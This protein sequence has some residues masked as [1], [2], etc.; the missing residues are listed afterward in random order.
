MQKY[1]SPG[2]DVIRRIDW[3]ICFEK[4]QISFQNG[5]EGMAGRGRGT[6]V[7]VGEES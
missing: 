2:E 4:K 5:E 1:H 3:R 7:G 6:F